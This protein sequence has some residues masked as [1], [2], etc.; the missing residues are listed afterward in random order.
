MD[1]NTARTLGLLFCVAIPIWILLFIF[2]YCS[3][4]DR[5]K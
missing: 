2:A 4:K 3:W 5:Q 1:D